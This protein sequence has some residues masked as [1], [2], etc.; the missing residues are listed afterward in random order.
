[1]DTDEVVM[2]DTQ[3]EVVVHTEK[4]TMDTDEVV[5]TDTQEEVVVHMEKVTMD[6]DEVVMVSPEVIA[7]VIVLTRLRR[8]EP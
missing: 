6:M 4:D 2:T 1:M 5:M 8:R 7:A 3:E